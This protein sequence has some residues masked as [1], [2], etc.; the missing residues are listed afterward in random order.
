MPYSTN[1]FAW[2]LTYFNSVIH[3]RQKKRRTEESCI[4]GAERG[5]VSREGERLLT[6][7]ILQKTI[8]DQPWP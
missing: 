8:W 5:A 3:S 6:V 2:V 7:A 4:E 1:F